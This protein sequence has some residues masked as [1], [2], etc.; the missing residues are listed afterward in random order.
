MAKISL[1]ISDDAWSRFRQ[2]VFTR[3]GTLRK[4]SDEV[5]GLISSEDMEKVIESC[6]RN[7][8]ISIDRD[9]TSA[10]VKRNRP[11]S[12]GASSETILRNMR[13]HRHGRRVHR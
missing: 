2:K 5:E 13:D 11:K 8:R 9:I 7:L 6:A 3:Y 4:L 1:Y 12:R 10:E